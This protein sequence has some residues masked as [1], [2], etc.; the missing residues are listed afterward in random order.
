ME[1][2]LW[3]ALEVS[4]M[5]FGVVSEVL[6]AVGVVLPVGEIFGAIGGAM[7]VGIAEA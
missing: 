3:G 1:V 5:S 6:N 4:Q 2:L 7:G